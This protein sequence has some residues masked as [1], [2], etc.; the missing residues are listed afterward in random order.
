MILIFFILKMTSGAA[1][2]DYSGGVAKTVS[3]FSKFERI[4][5]IMEGWFFIFSSFISGIKNFVA[6]QLG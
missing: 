2:S 4:K 1:P 3:M 5:K 6:R